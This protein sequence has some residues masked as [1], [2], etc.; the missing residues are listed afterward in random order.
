LSTTHSGRVAVVTGAATGLGRAFADRLSADGALVAVVDVDEAGAQAVAR[1][2]TKRGG[3]AVAVVCDVSRPDDVTRMALE[4][5]RVLGPATIVVNNAGLSPHISLDDLTFE[6]WR[7]VM[8]V[9]ADGMFLVIKAFL[10][11]MRHER[12]GRIVNVASNTYGLV[13]PGFTHYV[14]SK[15]AVIGLTRAVATELGPEGITANAVAP[16]LTRT[17]SVV[18]R[19][20]ATG[21]FEQMAQM[22]AIKRSE[23]PEDVAGVV[24]FLASEDARFV[25]G[26][27]IV[28]DG[29]LVRH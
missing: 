6:A 19:M 18:E 14:A 5:E 12:F 9:N 3:E 20:E 13:I 29:G 24:S 4:V 28:V 11:Q 27:T 2:I 17:E 10:G 26:Q 23:V 16:G 25:T 22:Q 15:G 21:L 7:Q 1:E 8:A